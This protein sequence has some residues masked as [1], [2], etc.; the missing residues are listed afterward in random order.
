MYCVYWIH[1]PNHTDITSQG[2]VGITSRSER[3]ELRLY[4][5]RIQRTNQHLSNAFDLYG[6]TIIQT[7]LVKGSKEYCLEI[8]KKLRPNNHIGW[9]IAPGGGI[10]KSRKG[11]GPTK[12]S[13]VKGHS[14]SEDTKQ[15][16][17]KANIGKVL[18][19]D[20]KKK[21]GIK[22]KGKIISNC[23]REKA[24][25]ATHKY[26]EENGTDCDHLWRITKNDFV[27]ETKNIEK[28]CREQGLK[29]HSF[30]RSARTNKKSRLGFLVER[31]V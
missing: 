23:T 6:N 1:L 24:R 27:V 14:V 28:W 8:E 18:N 16:L 17:Y 5:H 12:T 4:E 21:I 11:M 7:I 13:F 22:H 19:E 10:P 31:L 9:N 26:Y 20:H 2:Y 29:P 30:Y 25:I 15:K 3:A